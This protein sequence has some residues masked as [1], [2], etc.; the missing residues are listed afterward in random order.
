MVE[1]G[2]HNPLVGGSNPSA[3][4]RIGEFRNGSRGA[5]STLYQAVIWRGSVSGGDLIGP[6]HLR[7]I[8]DGM[9]P[10]R[11]A[12]IINPLQRFFAGCEKPT[13]RAGFLSLNLARNDTQRR[14]VHA[15]ETA[16]FTRLVES[17][18]RAS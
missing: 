8:R 2:N 12:K 18:P 1:Q 5:E 4:T 13:A 9:E 17:T 10:R 15:A 14:L 16:R 11:G 7:S 3:A 6:L